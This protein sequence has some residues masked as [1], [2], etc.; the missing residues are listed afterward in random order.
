METLCHW[1]HY[2]AEVL[3][4]VNP[5]M[6]IFACCMWVKLYCATSK[7]LSEACMRAYV[8]ERQIDFIIHSGKYGVPISKE[9][10]DHLDMLRRMSE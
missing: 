1:F 2:I 6:M 5:M 7:R 8:L 4:Y 3:Y 10:L 9:D